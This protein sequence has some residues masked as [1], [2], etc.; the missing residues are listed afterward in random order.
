VLGDDAGVPSP[1]LRRLALTT[2]L[3][4]GLGL[5]VGVRARR[6]SPRART[7][8]LLPRP[9]A[10][11]VRWRSP[12]PTGA[13]LKAK[14]ADGTIRWV[15]PERQQGR[16]EAR[17]TGLPPGLPVQVQL[18]Y[19]DGTEGPPGLATPLGLGALAPAL[20][21][22]GPR[23]LRVYFEA[24]GQRGSLVL[25]G[26]VHR[27]DGAVE[28]LA[29]TPPDGSAGSL[30]YRLEI[31]GAGG[32]FEGVLPLP[33]LIDEV[34]TRRGQV[35]SSREE[36]EDPLA[37]PVR[38]FL[39]LSSDAT[40]AGRR[41]L[42]DLLEPLRD[43][44]SRVRSRGR[45]PRPDP[46]SWLPRAL[47]PGAAPRAGSSVEFDPGVAFTD[48]ASAEWTDMTAPRPPGL[49][50]AKAV[51]ITYD[52]PGNVP[53]DV[54]ARIEFPGGLRLTDS[55]LGVSERA[56]GLDPGWLPREG[57]IRLRVKVAALTAAG[58]SENPMI[59]SRFRLVVDP[60]W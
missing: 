3:G 10:L 47:R 29:R 4:A 39:A 34:A 2:A 23:S 27:L 5:V 52:V 15:D 48:P 14:L 37:R 60:K 12:E 33:G 56:H 51:A 22:V 19:P 13:R 43:R 35:G 53:E 38:E 11:L 16:S 30:P 41:E 49:A 25:D 36:G 57:P 46:E 32:P 7:T 21:R 1:A 44:A 26:E 17:I 8:Q 9:A 6:A 50:T 45:R 40:A 54:V 59:L 24:P 28:Y 31:E 58:R 42:Y 20:H 18:V 55:M